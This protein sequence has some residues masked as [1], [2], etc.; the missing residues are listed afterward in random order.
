[1]DDLLGPVDELGRLLALTLH[2]EARDLTP[3]AHQAPERG[4]LADDA[5]VVAGIRGGRDEG[6]QLVDADTAA[7][8]FELA[9][10]LELVYERD[11]VH[12]LTPPVQA[13]RRA[14]DLGVALAIEVGC[15]KCLADR[16][17]RT[18]G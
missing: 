12:R 5:G 18:G 8:L 14:V 1:E 17:D 2:P 13:E 9:F 6:R 16:P 4:H 7:D 11:R 3:R 10:P 15:R